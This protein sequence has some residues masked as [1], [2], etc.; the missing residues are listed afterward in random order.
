[1]EALA[2]CR[3]TLVKFGGHAMAAGLSVEDS[4]I[5]NFSLRFNEVCSALSTGAGVPEFVI[6]SAVSAED[7]TEELAVG[8]ASMGPFGAGNPEPI[9]MLDRAEIVSRRIVG[10]GH[11]KLRIRAGDS[12]FDSI[13]FGMADSVAP[14]ARMVSAAFTPEMNT[15]QGRNS[16][17]LKL[18]ALKP[19]S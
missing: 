10:N 4:L 19:A 15:W 13:G 5:D 14:D 1:V 2:S 3:E 18:C 8:I 12:H 17:Q 9:L 7:L 16:L 6:D 11:L